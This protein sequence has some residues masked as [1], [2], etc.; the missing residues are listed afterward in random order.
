MIKRTLCL[1]LS[2]LTASFLGS[3]SICCISIILPWLSHSL[4]VLTQHPVCYSMYLKNH[5]ILSIYF[6]CARAW[7]GKSV[8]QCIYGGQ[9]TA[10][11]CESQ[12]SPYYKIG[13]GDPAYSLRLVNWYL[14]LLSHLVCPTCTLRLEL[15]W[16]CFSSSAFKFA[17]LVPLVGSHHACTKLVLMLTVQSA[18]FRDTTLWLEGGCCLGDRQGKHG[19]L[20]P[21]RNTNCNRCLISGHAMPTMRAGR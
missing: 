5:C 1:P 12:L 3:S 2:H 17:S 14:Y 9:R 15:V 21:G 8:L 11:I 20:T 7:R 18:R 4:K 19:F 13:P 6:V 16:F 10:W